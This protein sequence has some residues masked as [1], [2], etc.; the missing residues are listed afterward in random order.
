MKTKIPTRKKLQDATNIVLS[1]RTQP[2]LQQ[3]QTYY[4]PNPH[5]SSQKTN[6]PNPRYNSQPRRRR[7][8]INPA[9]PEEE[10]KSIQQQAK[11]ENKS[12]QQQARK[13]RTNQPELIATGL[14]IDRT[15]LVDKPVTLLAKIK[16]RKV[17]QHIQAELSST[18]SSLPILAR[19]IKTL[20]QN[21]GELRRT[22]LDSLQT[23]LVNLQARLSDDGKNGLQDRIEKLEQLINDVRIISTNAG[24]KQLVKGQ[25]RKVCVDSITGIDRERQAHGA[26][27]L[28][29]ALAD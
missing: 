9:S 25:R 13:K 22:S 24:I 6:Q 7:E 15:K 1:T 26:G 11:Q 12:T 3:Q 5:C 27:V 8:Q 21:G 28:R 4:R 17:R 2:S 23:L 19:I 18:N 10:N 20:A 16:N 29:A 14:G